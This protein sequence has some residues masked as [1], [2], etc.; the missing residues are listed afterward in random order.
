MIGGMTG[1][2]D[3]KREMIGGMGG[4]SGLHRKPISRGK[5]KIKTHHQEA[6]VCHHGFALYL[7]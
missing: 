5:I 6:A 4:I 2:M 3:R 1:T 7:A